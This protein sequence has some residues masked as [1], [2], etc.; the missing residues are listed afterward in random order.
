[1]HLSQLR[2]DLQKQNNVECQKVCVRRKFYVLLRSYSLNEENKKNQQHSAKSYISKKQ[3]YFVKSSEKEK[4][5]KKH[6]EGAISLGRGG[7]RIM[8]W[9][10]SL[11]I[12]RSQNNTFTS[13]S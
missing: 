1:M 8:S 3:N 10:S 13:S 4:M 5:S 2:R 7:D 6:G 9:S 12:Y 11:N